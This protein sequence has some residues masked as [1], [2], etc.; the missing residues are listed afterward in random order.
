MYS[1]VVI[2]MLFYFEMEATWCGTFSV[3]SY[4]T[5]HIIAM[6]ISI[7][8]EALLC[9]AYLPL[10]GDC[11]RSDYSGGHIVMYIVL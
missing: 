7:N 4:L 3:I 10:Q 2:F 6:K 5:I 8:T 9:V 1:H 11:E